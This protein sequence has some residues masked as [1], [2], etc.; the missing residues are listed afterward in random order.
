MEKGATVELFRDVIVRYSEAYEGTV[1]YVKDRARFIMTTS[2]DISYN[3]A[4]RRGLFYVT[5]GSQIYLNEARI[6]GNSGG[7]DSIIL[8][9]ENNRV[10]YHKVDGSTSISAME[11]TYVKSWLENLDI[12]RNRI[13]E[14][15]RLISIV[16]SNFTVSNSTFTSNEISTDSY[17]IYASYAEVDIIRSKF[18][19]PTD[20]Y[21][22][23]DLDNFEYS[24]VNGAFVQA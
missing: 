6:F 5:D 20:P 13:A 22:H 2:I 9:A 11:S 1:A 24:D 19:G 17:G 23:Y 4:H 14:R 21:I 7:Y 10:E 15:G 8:H 3:K 12:S 16:E 18:V